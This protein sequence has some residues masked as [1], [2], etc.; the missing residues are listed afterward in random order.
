[1][2]ANEKLVGPKLPP[3]IP[4]IAQRAL[5]TALLVGCLLVQVPP[6]TNWYVNL[7]AAIQREGVNLVGYIAASLVLA[8]FCMRSMCALRLIALTSNLAFIAYGYLA[9]LQPVLVLHFILLPVNA[10]RL[11]QLTK[12]PADSKETSKA[13]TVQSL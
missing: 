3:R 8:T 7:F 5:A 11:L 4:A 9:D 1:M 10:Y 2:S 13:L 12:L 6:G